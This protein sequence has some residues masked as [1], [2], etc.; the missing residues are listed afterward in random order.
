MSP[1]STAANTGYN[2]Q[3]QQQQHQQQQL[4]LLQPPHHPHT[5]A[6]AV[7]GGSALGC[8]NSCSPNEMTKIEDNN[9]YPS[10]HTVVDADGNKHSENVKRFSV[11]NLLELAND[12]RISGKLQHQHQQHQQHQRQHRHE[13]MEDD[14][15]DTQINDL[16][17]ST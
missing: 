8:S 12:C 13:P 1:N 15:D 11:N 10:L 3:Q 14:L 2:H 7:G 17:G 4:Q 6:I 9:N 5:D 16:G